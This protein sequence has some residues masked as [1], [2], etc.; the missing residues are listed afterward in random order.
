[1]SLPATATLELLEFNRCLLG[2]AA[3]LA[4][5]MAGDGADWYA[6]MPGP[7]LRHVIEHLEALVF[8][9]LPDVVDYD[10]RPRDRELE[11][12][13]VLAKRRLHALQRALQGWSPEALERPLT[14]R[15][16]GGRAG[17]F[18]FEVGSSVGRE[19]AFLASHTVHH[20]ALLQ[21]ACRE[22]GIAVGTDFGKAPATVAHERAQR[23]AGATVA[24]ATQPVP[25]YSHSAPPD[26]SSAFP[27]PLPKE[28]P[29]SVA[30][31]TA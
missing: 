8:A 1:M 3:E 29:C 13:P 31:A 4:E 21:D 19:L 22:R 7:H 17:E 9:P 15:G 24:A 2:Q 11:R 23:T 10:S 12:C 6:G 18:A 16:V 14:V 5:A 28:I 20:F 26:P 25:R 27:S 30:P